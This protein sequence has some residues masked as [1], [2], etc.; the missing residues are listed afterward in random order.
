MLGL[1][2]KHIA[3]SDFAESDTAT[4]GL[5]FSS[6]MVAPLLIVPV[7]LNFE[8]LV[9]LLLVWTHA[10]RAPAES[11]EKVVLVG[12]TALVLGKIISLVSSA[13]KV[14]AAR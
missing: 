7:L 13:S 12:N 1:G 9:G 6:N 10:V 3:T 14:N 5:W 4:E 11:L 2:L 8:D